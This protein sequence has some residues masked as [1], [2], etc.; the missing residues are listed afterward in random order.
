MAY[1]LEIVV[2]EAHEATGIEDEQIR[3]LLCMVV[4][5]ALG[6]ILWAV[7]RGTNLRHA[8]CIFFGL[9]L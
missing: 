2:Q 9:F 5:F 1:P 3:I 8:F 4:Q 7:V 6:W